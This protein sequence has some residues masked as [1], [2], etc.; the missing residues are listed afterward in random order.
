MGFFPWIKKYSIFYVIA[1]WRI[2]SN[3][4]ANQ[5]FI[6]PTAR[7][8]KKHFKLDIAN[9]WVNNRTRGNI[10]MIGVELRCCECCWHWLPYGPLVPGRWMWKSWMGW[11]WGTVNLGEEVEG[12]RATNRLTQVSRPPLTANS[13][14]KGT[15]PPPHISFWRA[16][17]V[18]GFQFFCDGLCRR[19]PQIR[20]GCSLHEILHFPLSRIHVGR[21]FFYIHV[22]YRQFRIPGGEWETEMVLASPPPS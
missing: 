12:P 3:V 7:F 21:I 11:G 22:V 2:K 14:V 20:A 16:S 17:H 1:C 10:Q 6:Y 9:I 15:R 5:T 18:Q 4:C 19:P 13:S 8:F